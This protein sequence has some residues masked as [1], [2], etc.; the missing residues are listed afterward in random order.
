M[1]FGMKDP[2]DC[3]VLGEIVILAVSVTEGTLTSIRLSDKGGGGGEKVDQVTVGDAACHISLEKDSVTVA[4]YMEAVSQCKVSPE[5]K[6]SEL[7]TSRQ[8]LDLN[9]TMVVPSRQEKSH[10][11]CFLVAQAGFGLLC[12]LGSDAVICYDLNTL[13]FLDNGVIKVPGGPRHCAGHRT[14]KQVFYV[15]CELSNEVSKLVIEKG[16]DG[17]INH[18]LS[19]PLSTLPAGFEGVTHVAAIKIHPSGKFLFVSNRSDH[20][21]SIATFH[22]DPSTGD[23]S[24]FSQAKCPAIPRDIQI[25]ANGK[26]L[27]VAA[28]NASQVCV[29]TIDDVGVLTST[30]KS[31]FFYSSQVNF[32]R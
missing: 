31:F 18:V 15:A 28:Q 4:A 19:K 10:P 2:S 23:L 12:D 24:S 8:N 5:G 16:A 9:G 22:I 21:S 7:Q 3:E 20:D 30:S 6:F 14:M 27:L 1:V 29:F 13:A 17:R 26:L 32:C 25:S 11:H